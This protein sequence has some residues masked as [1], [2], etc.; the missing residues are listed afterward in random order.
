MTAQRQYFEITENNDWEGETW[1][2]FVPLAPDEELKLRQYV[3]AAGSAYRMAAEPTPLIT[4][5]VLLEREG[6]TT[7]YGEYCRCAPLEK[8]IPDVFDTENDV[9]YKGG[10]FKVIEQCR[11]P[12]MEID[13]D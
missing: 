10:L 7:Y 3:K 4:I 12:V 2:F 8:A 5:E 13:E 6:A 11:P 9:L 1:H